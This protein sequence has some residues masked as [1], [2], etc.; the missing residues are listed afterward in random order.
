MAQIIAGAAI[1]RGPTFTALPER[2]LDLAQRDRTHPWLT[3]LDGSK[4]TYEELLKNADP[5]IARYVSRV[6]WQQQF[7]A[8]H[9]AYAKVLD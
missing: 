6:V 1:P 8:I 5:A 3:D 4:T 9:Q 2:W 7:A